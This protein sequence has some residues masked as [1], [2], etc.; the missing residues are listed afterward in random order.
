MAI[1]SA[2]EPGQRELRLRSAAGLSNPL[3]FHVG[4]LPELC[5]K[6]VRGDKEPKAF[7][8]PKPGPQAKSTLPEPPID[9]T[10]PSVVNGQIMPGEVDRYQ[11]RAHKG[12]QLIVAASARELIPYLADAVPGWFQAALAHLRF[13]RGG[14][15]L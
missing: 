10:L 13:P 4:Q 5:K 15:G 1:D 11:F 8:D 6:E 7:G 3:A 2:A 12:Q 9:I 14:S